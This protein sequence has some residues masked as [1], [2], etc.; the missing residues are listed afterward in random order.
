LRWGCWGARASSPF[1]K[2]WSGGDDSDDVDDGSQTF[3][4]T[5]DISRLESFVEQRGEVGVLLPVQELGLR[6][7]DVRRIV[8]KSS[9][10]KFSGSGKT[11][12]VVGFPALTNERQEATE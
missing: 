9:K 2:E 4:T 3:P 10:M 12:S 6:V 1:F 5:R 8:A 11:I 7:D